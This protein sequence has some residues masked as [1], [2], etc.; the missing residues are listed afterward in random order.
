MFRLRCISS[1]H[2]VLLR[3]SQR[4]PPSIWDPLE[5]VKVKKGDMM[6]EMLQ[7]GYRHDSYWTSELSFALVLETFVQVVGNDQCDDTVRE[8]ARNI[9]TSSKYSRMRSK[10]HEIC[11][12]AT[13][14]SKQ[15][16]FFRDFHKTVKHA[17]V[18]YRAICSLSLRL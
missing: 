15:S 17:L 13:V 11:P 9:N 6:E 2:R 3:S 10:S 16:I 12:K 1:D 14:K 18:S 4:E 8:S 5:T 7:F